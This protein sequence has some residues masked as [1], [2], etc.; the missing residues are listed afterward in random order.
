MRGT[1]Q[2][3]Y[4]GYHC[5]ACICIQFSGVHACRAPRRAGFQWID[6]RSDEAT[7]DR[8][9]PAAQQYT[10]TAAVPPRAGRWG[11]L[12]KIQ[13]LFVR[14][15][16]PIWCMRCQPP[17][18]QLGLVRK[19]KIGKNCRPLKDAQKAA[20]REP[21]MLCCMSRLATG[22]PRAAWWALLIPVPQLLRIAFILMR[23]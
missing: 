1:H 8:V 22:L 11:I 15:I 18:D 16:R 23:I 3:H 6:P 7:V 2:R 13:F 9:K 10:G 14:C 21:P 19:H 4:T 17:I 12:P 20:L 5:S